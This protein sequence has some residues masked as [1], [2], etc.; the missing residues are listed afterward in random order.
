MYSVNSNLWVTQPLLA[1]ELVMLHQLLHVS[2]SRGN[3]LTSQPHYAVLNEVFHS[4]SQYF[5]LIAGMEPLIRSEPHPST[6]FMAVQCYV[7]YVYWTVH[8]C[9]N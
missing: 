6:S 9:D 8:H 5:Q 1:H 4:F 2:Y 7:S 3:V